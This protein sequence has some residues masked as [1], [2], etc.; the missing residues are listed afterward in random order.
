MKRD[1]VMQS[2][3][4]DTSHTVEEESGVQV[5]WFEETDQ[6]SHGEIS[7]LQPAASLPAIDPTLLNFDQY[8]A[9][10]NI[11]WHLDQTLSGNKSPPLRMILYGEGGTGKLKVI[12]TVT[13]AFPQRGVKYMLMKST[14]TRVAA[15]LLIGKTSHN[16]ASLSMSS[17][18]SLSDECKA[19]LQKFWDYKH[20][21][22]INE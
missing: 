6:E 3:D 19:K 5:G 13:Q 21:L 9:Y 11:Q 1:I 12:Q 18:G 14:Y 17:D 2:T 7:M 10:N 8:W 15:S 4:S 22:V 16:I 20:Y